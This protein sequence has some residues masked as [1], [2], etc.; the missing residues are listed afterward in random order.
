MGGGGAT[1]FSCPTSIVDKLGW[2]DVVVGV[3]TIDDR[4]LSSYKYFT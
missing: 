1:S 2:V 3:V 4:K